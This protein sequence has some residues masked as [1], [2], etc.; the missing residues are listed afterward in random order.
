MTDFLF[1]NDATE[2]QS[3]VVNN[4]DEW[5]ILVIDD[6]DDIH[7][8]TKLVLSGFN[9][10]GKKLHFHHAYSAAEAKTK[11]KELQ[12]VAVC[13]VDVVMETTHAGLDLIKYIREDEQNHDVRLV[14]RTGQPGE[15]PEESVIRDYDIN[16]YKNKTE[17]TAIKLKTLLYSA[18]RAYRDIRTIEKH[19][20]SLEKIIDAS[21][22]FLQCDTVNQ[23]ASTILDHVSDVMGL[24][25]NEIYCAAAVNSQ[26]KPASDFKL[27]AASGITDTNENTEVPEEIKELF[28]N[29]HNKKESL[30]NDNQFV[31]YFPTKDGLE[32]MLYV[33]KSSKLQPSDHQLLEFFSNNISLAYDNLCLR[34]T[35]RESQKELSYILGE[36]IEKRSKET[37]SHVKRVANYSYMLAIKYG[38]TPYQAEIIK[39]ASPLHDIG[40]IAIPDMILN[41]P[42]KHDANEWDIMQSHAQQGY[43][44]LKNSNNEILQQ[45]AL[46]AYQHHEKW[47]GSGYPQGL[48]GENIDISGRITALADVFDALGSDR[49][50]KKAWPLEK[51]IGLLKEERGKHFDPKLIDLFLDDLDAFLAIRDSF[52]D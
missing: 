47:D 3:P 1:A 15:A 17:L 18:L 28:V 52:P 22:H 14:L 48:K 46:L 30:K 25:D 23:F 39:F 10:E 35:V 29:A 42:G 16:D 21:A 49:C 6:E 5:D 7:Q 4:L 33:S 34:E 11:I 12:N 51:I 36:A 19:K 8:V 41:K 45:G 38:L 50:Y 37:G 31:G 32:T 9:F 40:K 24:E 20:H 27:L 43:D 13:L 44:I 26:S 2:T